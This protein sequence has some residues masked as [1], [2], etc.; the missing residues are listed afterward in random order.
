MP[1]LDAGDDRLFRHFLR[2]RLDHHDAV[3]G[4]DDH[5]VEL[6]FALFVVGR[7]D[8][9][10]AVHLS[11]A[12][13]ANR[14]VKRNVRH[15][16]RHRRTVNAGNIGIVGGIRRQ[17]HG[18]DLGLAAEAFGEQRPNRAID[19]PAGQNLALAGTPFALDESARNASGGVGVLAVI[20][21]E[22]E[23]V[24]ALAGIGVGA[25]GGENHVIANAHYAGTVCLLR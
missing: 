6:A 11:D 20:H 24:D 2:A 18:D 4:A 1:E 12:H 3:H 22:G 5:Q 10:L 14:A 17:H 16:Q 7:I 23:E 13:R 21:R 25:S 19:L 15:A 9:E 8:D